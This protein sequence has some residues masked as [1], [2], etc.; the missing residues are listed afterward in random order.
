MIPFTDAALFLA[1]PL[2]VWVVVGAYAAKARRQSSGSAVMHGALVSTL[3]L[4]GAAVATELVL[5]ATGRAGPPPCGEE[6]WRWGL[7]LILAW[8]RMFPA[9]SLLGGLLYVST[10]GRIPLAGQLGAIAV[11]QVGAAIAG[12]LSLPSVPSGLFHV[13]QACV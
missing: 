3:L 11:V 12:L 1:V 5:W 6:T 7:M 10:S 2:A 9:A 8:S 4:V 13:A